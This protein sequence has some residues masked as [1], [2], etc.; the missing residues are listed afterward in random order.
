MKKIILYTLLISLNISLF[1]QKKPQNEEYRRSSLYSFLISHPTKR[2]NKEIVIAYLSTPT[3]D[4]FNNHDLSIK[5]VV[6]D[7]RKKEK[8]SA[9]DNYLKNNQIAK[10]M[11]SKWFSRD[12]KTGAFDG[13]LISNRGLYDATIVDVQTAKLSKR[14]MAMLSDAGNELIGNTFVIVNDITYVDKEQGAQIAAA[15]F[16]AIASV[17]GAVGGSGGDIA[18]SVAELSGTIS[19]MIAGFTVNIT[20]HLFQLN[21]NDTIANT[22]YDQYYFDKNSVD[23]QKKLAFETDSTLF[24]LKY[25]GS[26]SARSSKTVMRGLK[27]PE[28]VFRK[29]CARAI[30]ENVV[31]LQKEYDVFKV[32]TPILTIDKNFV[33]ASIGLKEGVSEKSR[34]EVLEQM[35]SE[36]GKTEYKRVGVIAP[37][38][39]QIWDNRYMAVEEE[40]DGADLGSTTFEIVSGSDFY[41]GMLIRETKYTSGN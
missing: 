33:T 27:K 40:A 9:I 38:K 1:A 36:D 17:A 26:Y 35:Q 20:T 13:Q 37:V 14:G 21:W 32:K 7:S 16:S 11:V 6:T 23:S 19:D 24:K 8:E 3:I 28:D 4:K 25:I 2:M 22:F 34:Y 15:I 30:D 29:V 12:K 39:G 31:K 18:E 41:P 10:R 5:Y